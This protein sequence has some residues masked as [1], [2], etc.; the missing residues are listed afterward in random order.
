MGLE[1]KSSTRVGRQATKAWSGYATSWAI[2]SMSE[3]SST[4]DSSRFRLGD[5]V[6]ALPIG[7]LWSPP[8]SSRKATRATDGGG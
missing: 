6:W 4:P 2:D 1:V 7:A 5:R 3:W 8:E